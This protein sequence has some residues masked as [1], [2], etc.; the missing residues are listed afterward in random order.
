VATD[1]AFRLSLDP[2]E[3]AEDWVLALTFRL[4]VAWPQ[5]NYSDSA[6]RRFVVYPLAMKAALFFVLASAVAAQV[7]PIP[8]AGATAPAPVYTTEPEYPEEARQAKIEGTVT[9]LVVIGRDG[10]IQRNH[11]EVA[12]SLGLSLDE[13]A[14]QCVW[15]W[16][17]IPG[18]KDGVPVAMPASIKITFPPSNKPAKL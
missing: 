15:Q 6:A 1:E 18:T 9:L 12:H 17:F 4:V 11:N 3:A 16:R 7:R 2:L 13:K 8:P 5:V 10:R 14:I